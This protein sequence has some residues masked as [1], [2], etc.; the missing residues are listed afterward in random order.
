ME[1]KCKKSLKEYD[2]LL[3]FDLASKN[4]G[5]CLWNL[6][7]SKPVYTTALHVVG[8]EELPVSELNNVLKG[9][10]KHLMIDLGIPLKKTLIMKEAMPT[11]LRGGSSTIQTFVAIAR[12]HAIFDLLVYSNDLD[13]YDYVG[14]Y[15]ITWHNYFKKVSGLSKDDKVTKELVHDY[16][17]QNYGLGEDI[18]LDETDAV[19]MCK[20]FLDIKWNADVQEGIRELKRHRKTLKAA[21]AI[22]SYDEKIHALEALKIA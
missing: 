7:T 22:I 15:P 3:M 4:T 19:F 18:S 20:T 10:F 17:V 16:V 6:K 1:I 5:V 2:Y 14:I 21:H 8:K 12:S 13:M 9:L 11:Q